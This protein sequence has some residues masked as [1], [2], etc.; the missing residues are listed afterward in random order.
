[1][2]AKRRLSWTRKTSPGFVSLATGLFLMGHASCGFAQSP[3]WTQTSAPDGPWTSMAVSADE[4]KLVAVA[5]G[6]EGP[7]PQIQRVLVARFHVTRQVQ[8]PRRVT[9]RPAADHLAVQPNRRV[10]HRAVHIEENALAGVCLRD[11]QPLSIPTDARACSSSHAAAARANERTFDC[12]VMRQIYLSP[13]AVIKI[14]LHICCIT[15]SRSEQI[16][17]NRVG[18]RPVAGRVKVQMITGVVS[19]QKIHRVPGSR[20]MASKSITPS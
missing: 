14:Q 2:T 17:I 10:R 3:V 9:K 15:S 6:S 16:Q 18:H 20:T 4:S 19:R 11:V 12:P 8:P 13:R 5:G 1:M 7:Y